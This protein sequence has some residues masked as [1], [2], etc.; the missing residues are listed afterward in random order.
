MDASPRPTG[1]DAAG[2]V[3]GSAAQTT[4]WWRAVRVARVAALAVA[5]CAASCMLAVAALDEGWRMVC[6]MQARV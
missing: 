3:V 2:R 1:D 5:G 4:G 6:L